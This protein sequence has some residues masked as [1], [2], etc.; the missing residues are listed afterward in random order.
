[1]VLPEDTPESDWLVLSWQVGW[2]C[3]L[4]WWGWRKGWTQLGMLTRNAC[5][6]PLK[7]GGLRIVELVSTRQLRIQKAG[8]SCPSSQRLSLELPYRHI[9]YPILVK[10]VTAQSTHKRRSV[11]A[12]VVTFNP[13]SQ[14][15][16]ELH[17]RQPWFINYWI[18]KSKHLRLKKIFERR[19]G[20]V[21][22]RATD[23]LITY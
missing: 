15:K 1:M 7:Y 9:Y 22:L 3:L 19:R 11:K 21:I 23:I 2:S 20:K 16:S 17:P 6:C 5:S 8:G 12:F 4:P 10:A 13:P 14:S 18:L